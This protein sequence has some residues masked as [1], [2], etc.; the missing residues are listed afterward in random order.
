MINVFCGNA[1]IVAFS[2]QSRRVSAE[3][4]ECAA[5]D[6]GLV[7]GAASK[8]TGQEREGNERPARPGFLRRLLRRRNLEPAPEL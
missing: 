1:L 5:R 7:E 4:V 2:R 3:M 8:P 6:I